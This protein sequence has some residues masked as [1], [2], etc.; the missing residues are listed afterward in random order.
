MPDIIM[1]AR[2][3]LE[4]ALATGRHGAMMGE[5]GVMISLRDDL[6]LAMV[7]ARAGKG[8]DLARRTSASFGLDLPTTPRHVQQG[9]V[10]FTWA[11][12]G[13]WLAAMQ[14][15]SPHAFER[16]LR[17]EF[18]GLGSVSNQSDGRSIIRLGGPKL[19]ETLAKGVPIDL[20]PRAFRPGDTALTEVAHINVHFW[21]MDETPVYEFAVF[22]SFAC[23]FCEWLLAASAEFGTAV[24]ASA[25]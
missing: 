3:G 25:D 20:D 1:T 16:R 24:G 18:V 2:P 9:A 22:R 13:R 12:P 5:P 8:D 14:G 23:A 17:E 6:A 11:G 4:S 21:Q 19:R 10:S 15:V 7:T